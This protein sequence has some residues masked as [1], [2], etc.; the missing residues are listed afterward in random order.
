MFTNEKASTGIEV[1][2]PIT[3]KVVWY[4]SFSSEELRINT[5]FMLTEIRT[6]TLSY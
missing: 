6:L 5:I 3:F 2:S 1:T 4:E